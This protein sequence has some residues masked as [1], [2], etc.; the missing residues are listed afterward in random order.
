MRGRKKLLLAMVFSV[1]LG[2][3]AFAQT[4]TKAD[5]GHSL[6]DFGA[7]QA[8]SADGLVPAYTGGINEIPNLPDG[9][10]STSWPNPF[11]SE[12]PIFV[13]TKENMGKYAAMLTPGIQAMLERYGNKGFVLDVYPS[14]RTMVYPDWVLKNTLQNAQ[15]A[16]LIPDDEGVTGSYGGIPF[17]VPTNGYEAMW[18]YYLSYT[19]A[20]CTYTQ[21]GYVVYPNGGTTF[22]GTTPDKWATPYYDQ[23]KTSLSGNIYRYFTATFDAPASQAGVAYLFEYPINFDKTGDITYFYSPGTRRTRLAPDFA[24]DTPIASYGGALN[25]DEI[26]LYKGEMD[27]FNFKL[28]GRKEMIVPYNDYDLDKN[29]ESQLD[30]PY[31]INPKLVR[32]E[33]HRVW[34][35]EATLKPGERHIYK[36]WDFYIDEDSYRILLTESYDHAGN[37]YKVGVDLPWMTYGTTDGNATSVAPTFAI[38]DLSKDNYSINVVFTKGFGYFHCNTQLPNMLDYTPQSLSR[39]AVQ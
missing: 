39:Q 9:N 32:W 33:V 24:Y 36:K 19:P 13:V 12:K 35:V 7:I 25:Y 31:F 16:Q 17:P 29:T 23:T 37:I 34:V 22:L 1:G 14:H 4:Y 21:Q 28:I 26:Y 6:T 2:L 38:F 18:D 5:L 20:F 27:K 15:T 10:P 30:N 8:A 3:P 11:A